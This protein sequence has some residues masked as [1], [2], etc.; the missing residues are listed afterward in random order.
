MMTGFAGQSFGHSSGLPW[1][2][3]MHRVIVSGIRKSV[4][5]LLH[6]NNVRVALNV[7]RRAVKIGL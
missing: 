6:M 1:A 5:V 3:D 4:L 2:M 7:G